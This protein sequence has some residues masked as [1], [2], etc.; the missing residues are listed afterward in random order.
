MSAWRGLART[1]GVRRL[2][3]STLFKATFR[4]Y[5]ASRPRFLSFAGGQFVN[6]ERPAIVSD[7]LKLVCFPFVHALPSMGSDTSGISA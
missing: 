1:K 4:A 5:P 2:A 6:H 3:S 7:Y